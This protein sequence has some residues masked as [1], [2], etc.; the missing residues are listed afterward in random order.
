MM[1]KSTLLERMEKKG[2]PKSWIAEV[3][4]LYAQIKRLQ[5]NNKMYLEIIDRLARQVEAADE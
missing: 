2:A 1:A 4:N 3:R 5:E